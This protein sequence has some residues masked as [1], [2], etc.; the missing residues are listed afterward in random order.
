[1]T[2]E[3]SV[4][5]PVGPTG[6]G[7]TAEERWRDRRRRRTGRRVPLRFA[8]RWVPVALLAGAA[9]GLAVKLVDTAPEVL[10]GGGDIIRMVMAVLLV[11]AIVVAG[12][13][14]V[15]MDDPRLAVAIPAFALAGIVTYPVAPTWVPGATTAGTYTLTLRG[16]TQ[17]TAAGVLR[18]TWRPGNY[19]MGELEAAEPAILADGERATMHA[20]FSGGHAWLDRVA[21]DGSPRVR[22][23]DTSP[24]VM[25]PPRDANLEP[26]R[27]ADGRAGRTTLSLEPEPGA[28]PPDGADGS[29]ATPLALA[30]DGVAVATLAWDCATP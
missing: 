4:V 11:V 27:T 26:Q 8:V 18:C 6:S 15:L 30:P 28:R 5:D 16:E 7:A 25:E 24:S 17:P 29:W 3:G 2:D 1:M 12:L 10:A 13:R 20:S 14:A 19:R 22:Y 9:T 21:A 23:V